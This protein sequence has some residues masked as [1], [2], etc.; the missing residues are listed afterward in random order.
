MNNNEIDDYLAQL[1]Q[2]GFNNG[3]SSKN[4]RHYIEKRLQ[5]DNISTGDVARILGRLDGNNGAGNG[6]GN[7]GVGNWNEG[8]GVEN[9]NNGEEN[10][11]ENEWNDEEEENDD[12][13]NTKFNSVIAEKMQEG[14]NK[15]VNN[16]QIKNY[17]FNELVNNGYNSEE[18][19]NVMNINNS[20]RRRSTRGHKRS[21]RGRKRS[22]RGHRRSTRGKQ[23]EK[24]R[25]LAVKLQREENKKGRQINQN[26]KLAM[27][28]QVNEMR[29]AGLNVPDCVNCEKPTRG[30]TVARG[31]TG[32]KRCLGSK[33][34]WSRGN[35]WKRHLARWYDI[36]DF[37]GG[38]DCFFFVMAAALGTTGEVI[39]RQCAERVDGGTIQALKEVIDPDIARARNRANDNTLNN[40][41]FEGMTISIQSVKWRGKQGN[42][43]RDLV[44]E[45]PDGRED[46]N[47][48]IWDAILARP[49]AV[50]IIKRVVGSM[51]TVN[52]FKTTVEIDAAD[53]I[54][55]D[56]SIIYEG[57]TWAIK[58]CAEIFP[59]VRIIVLPTTIEDV[60]SKYIFRRERFEDRRL[61]IMLMYS[62]AH[63]QIVRRK[64]SQMFIVSNRDLPGVVRN[65]LA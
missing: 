53:G 11:N 42:A 62:G 8:K 23:V 59:N 54:S 41:L 25:K 7:N 3:R 20:E 63:Y 48:D 58:Q 30:R 4:M 9:G 52:T 15:G 2:N 64:D 40:T 44:A 6:N 27:K 33:K 34:Q 5:A 35:V 26:R 57:N 32:R 39:R 1:Y 18:L 47:L 51:M 22:T 19:G 50:D 29:Q 56:V 49:D 12:V 14:Y 24:N 55:V 31:K 46:L 43:Y 10:W 17:V 21:T 45:Y 28:L 60:T 13:P 36:F 38:G 65:L 61:N 16:R 37:G